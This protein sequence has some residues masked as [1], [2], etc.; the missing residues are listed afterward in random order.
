MA[1]GLKFRIENVN[2]NYYLCSE[3]ETVDQL[4]SFRAAFSRLC[5]RICNKQL[6][7]HGIDKETGPGP[8]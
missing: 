6:F 7:L 1:R 3:K 5:F 2:G 4:R 8:V